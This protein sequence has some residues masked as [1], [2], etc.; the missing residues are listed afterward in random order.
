MVLLFR[1]TKKVGFLENYRLN[2]YFK[3]LSKEKKTKKKTVTKKLKKLNFES[4]L[5]K[6]KK[7]KFKS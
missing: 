4:N 7:V 2:K 3:W 1:F 6:K 5:R